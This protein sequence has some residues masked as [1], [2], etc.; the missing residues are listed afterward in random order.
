MKVNSFIYR[1]Q[2][3]SA[4]TRSRAFI[5]RLLL[6]YI[7]ILIIADRPFIISRDKFRI[8]RPAER[9]LPIL[10]VRYSKVI[11]TVLAFPC[12]RDTIIPIFYFGNVIKS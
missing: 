2:G 8:D 7:D 3:R 5:N 4:S 11:Q 6:I 9:A 1:F 10:F 12:N